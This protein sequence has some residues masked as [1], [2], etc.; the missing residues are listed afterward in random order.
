MSVGRGLSDILAEAGEEPLHG[1][2][3]VALHNLLQLGELG[4]YLLKLGR[5]VGIEHYLA[6]E[7]VVF[8]EEAACDVEMTLE[9]SARRILMLHDRSEHQC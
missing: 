7:I 3:V 8:A 1:V 5:G 6:E 4:A 2:G 9:G